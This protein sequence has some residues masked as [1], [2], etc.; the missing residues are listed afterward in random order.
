MGKFGIVVDKQKESIKSIIKRYMITLLCVNLACV[1]S[2][3]LD[4]SDFYSRSSDAAR[5]VVDYIFG[6]LMMFAVGSFFVESIFTEDGSNRKRL[7]LHYI[8]F[9]IFSVVFDILGNNIDIFSEAG[10]DMLYKVMVLY[11]LLCVVLAFHRLIKLSGMAFEKY[12]VSL[13]VGAIKVGTVLLLL[14][15]GFI[16]LVT[17][18]DILIVDVDEWQ[19]VTYVEILLV[20]IVYAPYALICLTDKTETKSRFIKGL[21]LWVLMPM[22]MAAMIIIY[23]YVLKILVTGYMPKNEVFGIC[24]GLFCIG[25]VIW[26]TAYPFAANAYQD[27][28]AGVIYRTVIKY[29]KYIYAPFILLECWSIGIRINDYG[30]TASRYWAVVFIILQIIYVAWE[31][32]Y[33]LVRKLFKKEKSGYAEGY[34][35]FLYIGILVYI[36]CVMLPFFSVEKI[37]FLSQKKRFEALMGAYETAYDIDLQQ[38]S[39][40]FKSARSIYNV[41]KWN[42]YGEEYLEEKYTAAELTAIKSFFGQQTYDGRQWVFRRRE[43]DAAVSIEGYSYMCSFRVD[44]DY[45]EEMSAGGERIDM[46]VDIE[47]IGNGNSIHDTINVKE[48]VWSMINS[49]YPNAGDDGTLPYEIVSESGRK[50]IITYCYFEY[51]ETDNDIR[52]WKFEGYV[53]W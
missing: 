17:I 33:G 35:H 16:L 53:L 47:D 15:I 18:F 4:A 37:E 39:D 14:N 30:I 29:A 52:D 28:K 7:I 45:Y 23:M 48:L 41:L 26:T 10:Q 25:A 36:L 49:D 24:A 2:V 22:V 21:L 32:I 13:V 8:I 34:E 38:N 3:A 5:Q 51:E 6:F 46:V 20:G 44:G 40:A 42:R 31:P 19:F 11:I 1:L 50:Y 27:L 43:T 9:A 12:M